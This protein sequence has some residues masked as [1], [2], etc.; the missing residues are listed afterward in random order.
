MHVP[1][2]M[3]HSFKCISSFWY[4]HVLKCHNDSVS[5]QY[6]SILSLTKMSDLLFSSFL[7]VGIDKSHYVIF[8][9]Q[10]YS[11]FYG[12]II[13]FPDGST[14]FSQLPVKNICST[15]LSPLFLHIMS[16]YLAVTHNLWFIKSL[17]YYE[18]RVISI[19]ENTLPDIILINNI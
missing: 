15:Y 11:Q 5:K 7:S 16:K 1:N 18:K 17:T 12:C 2:S 13:R 9:I 14:N 10:C 4:I 19:F 3:A 8:K 6:I